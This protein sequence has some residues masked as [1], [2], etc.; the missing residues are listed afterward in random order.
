MQISEE[1]I[2]HFLK[3]INVS[4]TLYRGMHVLSLTLFMTNLMKRFRERPHR[5]HL[6]RIWAVSRQNQQNDC[7]PSEDSDQPGHPPSLIRVFA[8]GS[9]GPKLSSCGQRRLW[10]DWADAQADLSLRWAHMPFYWFCREAA[11]FYRRSGDF[12][13]LLLML[14]SICK[15]NKHDCGKQTL[16]TRKKKKKKKKKKKSDACYFCRVTM[17]AV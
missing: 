5:R 2:K 4:D 10:S 9:E 16:S 11:R 17:V 14:I 7:T 12:I 3:H 15:Q 6:N 8:M 1:K 13:R